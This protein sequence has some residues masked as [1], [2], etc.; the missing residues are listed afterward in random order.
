MPEPYHPADPLAADGRREHRSEPIP[1]QANGLVAN[2]EPTLKE[3]VLDVPQRQRE[4]HVQQN[5][6]PD[7]SGEDWKY[8]H[9]FR[10][11]SSDRVS[12]HL[13]HAGLAATMPF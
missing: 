13:L 10:I 4:M 11:A 2:I 8:R 7:T 9:D 12:R 3:Q 5:R 6:K 1:P